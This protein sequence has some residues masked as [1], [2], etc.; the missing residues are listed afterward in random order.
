MKKVTILIIITAVVIALFGL[1]KATKS[2]AE[3]DAMIYKTS[4][5]GCCEFH[6][7]YL[8]SN[9]NVET[10]DLSQSELDQM[11]R[12]HDIPAEIQSCHTTLIENYIVEGHM[13][14]QAIDKLLEERPDIAGIALPGMPSGSPGMPGEKTEDWVIYAI[15]PDGSFEEFMR[16]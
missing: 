13:P 8:Q 11:K 6:A 9:F 14:K 5:C 7:I 2:S 1:F 15:N 4:F 12:E 16:L 3:H 10:E